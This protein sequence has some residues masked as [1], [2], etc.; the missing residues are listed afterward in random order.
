MTTKRPAVRK[1]RIQS[2]ARADAIL[3]VLAL[4][5]SGE[6]SLTEISDSLRL[7]KTTVFN[8]IRSL[9]D[10]EFVEQDAASKR[11]RLGKRNL[12]LGALVR[13]RLDVAQ[14]SGG[15]L[16]SLCA[17]SG[18]TVNLAVPKA[19][20][21]LIIESI[22]GRHGLRSTAYS[23]AFSDYHSSACGKAIFAFMPE[24]TRAALYATVELKAHTRFTLVE[25]K[26]IEAELQKVRETGLSRETEEN[27]LGQACI[28]APIFDGFGG[29]VGSI[30]VAGPVSRIVE[31]AAHHEQL[32]K[33]HTGRISA[34]LRSPSR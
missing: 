6:A 7:N 16:A 1:V 4:A 24:A 29:I 10:L 20:H 22:E 19:M 23:G 17:S 26:E 30:S 33:K 5:A 14:L 11:Y 15:E 31:N 3:G 28:G 18:E 9:I 12:E 2:L 25:P 34:S 21:A 27:E 32:L 13:R 8:L